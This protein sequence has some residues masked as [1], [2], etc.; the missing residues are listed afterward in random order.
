VGALATDTRACSVGA[1]A[2]VRGLPWEL[3]KVCEL[4]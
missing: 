1:A 3:V 2:N 4:R